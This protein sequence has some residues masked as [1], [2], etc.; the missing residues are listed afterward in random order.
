MLLNQSDLAC[1]VIGNAIEEIAAVGL[2]A[3]GLSL[4]LVERT[5]P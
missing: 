3:E 2:Q 5:L 1:G 4:G